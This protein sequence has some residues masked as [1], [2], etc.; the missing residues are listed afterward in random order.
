MAKRNVTVFDGIENEIENIN[1]PVYKVKKADLDN[2]KNYDS[3]IALLR[4]VGIS[5]VSKKNSLFK[6]Y[7]EAESGFSDVT[8][9]KVLVLAPQA[10]ETFIAVPNATIKGKYKTY[11]VVV[12]EHKTVLKVPTSRAYVIAL[13]D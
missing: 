6:S 5:N 10:D 4:K 8:G 3:V 11:M 7:D 12:D 9:M 2:C 13:T 1:M